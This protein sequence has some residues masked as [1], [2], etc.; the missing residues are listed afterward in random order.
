[1]EQALELM[2]IGQHHGYPTPLLDWSE[3]PFVAA[4]F[5]FSNNT[6][7]QGEAGAMVRIM[8]LSAPVLRPRPTPTD[9]LDPRFIVGILQPQAIGNPRAVPQQS[10]FTFSN[11]VDIEGFFDQLTLLL[12]RPLMTL[13]DI[14][15]RERR[16]ALRDLRAMGITDGSMFPG[17]D[18][19]CRDL[20]DLHFG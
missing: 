8:Q 1:M 7:K 17:I 18:G 11:I 2:S 4:F 10:V 3:S 14:D 13:I 15:I 6:L 19:T 9:L 5:A 20:S 12:G 16:V